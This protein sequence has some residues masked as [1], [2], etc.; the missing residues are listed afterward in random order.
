M[1]TVLDTL[2]TKFGFQTDT[3]GID[4][5]DKRVKDFKA[6][7]LKIAAGIGAVIGGAAFLKATA[8]AADETIKFADS[9]GVAVESLGKLEFATQR[10]GGSISGLRGSLSNISKAI[11]EVERGT[12]RAKLAFEDY[13]LS[14][15]DANGKTKTAD[16][17]LIELNQKF[18]GLT[19]AQQFDLAAKMGIDQGTIRLLQTAPDEVARLQMEAKKLGVLSRKDAA[20]AANFQDGLTNIAQSLNA[21]KFAIGGMVFNP[22][23]KLFK[24]IA[25]GIA[26]FRK[27][28]TAVIVGLGLIAA[29]FIAMK[30]AAIL[31]WLATLGPILLIP[32]AIAAVG[33]AIAILTE[34]FI[35]FFK[36]QD[37]FIGDLV[38]K[39]PMLGYALYAV[40]DA[41]VQLWEMSKY[42]FTWWLDIFEK[43][44]SSIKTFFEDP[45]KNALG[46]MKKIPGLGRVM[47]ALSMALPG[48]SPALAPAAPGGGSISK[49]SNV[50]VAEIKI[51]ARGSDSKEIA[52]NVGAALADQL[53][54]AV[55]D[56]DSDIER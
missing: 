42:A 15:K 24:M 12:G 55:E 14:V 38:K 22:L 40:R 33:A 49:S 34:D 23:A 8:A 27:H 44:G 3:S 51:D 10:Q 26:Y 18:A 20:A 35:A 25:S 17:L 11:G 4:K 19:R 16:Q 37:S 48:P 30:G 41:V 5:A 21:V 36:G 53:K 46:L 43:I 54:N 31:A 29:A 13:G 45:L 39:W 56:T 6:G 7:A 52:Q 9:V 28:K 32:A 47:G 2:V 50:S 1:A